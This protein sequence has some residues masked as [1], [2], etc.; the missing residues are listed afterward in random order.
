MMNKNL[1]VVET[2]KGLRRGLPFLRICGSLMVVEESATAVRYSK[3]FHAAHPW[4]EK[5]KNLYFL[6][7]IF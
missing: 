7:V 6:G 4:N 3:A 1:S 5:A 2:H